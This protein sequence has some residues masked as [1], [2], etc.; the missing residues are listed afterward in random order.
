VTGAAAGQF[1]ARLALGVMLLLTACTG[2]HSTAGGPPSGARPVTVASFDFVESEILAQLYAQA[3]E[4]KGYPVRLLL[5]AGTRELLGPALAEGLVDLVPEYSGS[6]LSFLTLG[7]QRASPSVE[8]THQALVEALAPSA[9]VALAPA[10][11]QD[12]NAVVVTQ[13]TAVRYGLAKISDLSSVASNFTFGGPP[14]CPQRPLCLLG[15]K[16]VYGLTFR[17]TIGLD[18][19]GT[20]TLQALRAGSI[21]V[22][23]MFTTDP[24]IAAEH[25]VVLTDDQRLQPAENITPMVRRAVLTQYGSA[26]TYAVD[27]VSARLTTLEL[28][29]LI[30]RVSLGGHPTRFVAAQWL[31]DQGLT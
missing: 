1:F 17:E 27:A 3:L 19:G 15:L 9:A 28:Q 21:D 14:E 26:F 7:E 31:K 10:P 2:G 6:A 18:T 20:L 25:L 24:A 29:A 11:A 16:N 5:R 4:A 30:G 23:L 22:A 13:A 8:L 12:A